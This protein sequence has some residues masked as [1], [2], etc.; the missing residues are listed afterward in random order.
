MY[1]SGPL[2]FLV[3]SWASAGG[4]PIPAWSHSR[5]LPVKVLMGPQSFSSAFRSPH[6]A[7]QTT[8]E[9]RKKEFIVYQLFTRMNYFWKDLHVMIWRLDIITHE[10]W[11]PYPHGNDPNMDRGVDREPL[12]F[13]LL[14]SFCSISPHSSNFFWGAQPKQKAWK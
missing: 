4:P 5:V 14:T 9:V 2:L 11:W 12:Q 8:A 1:G 3:P 7:R 6:W 10:F 13:A